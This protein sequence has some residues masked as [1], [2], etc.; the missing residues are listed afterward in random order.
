MKRSW[1]EFESLQVKGSFRAD[2]DYLGLG[3]CVG[4]K[5]MPL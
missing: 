5:P 1:K 4:L 3:F 2:S